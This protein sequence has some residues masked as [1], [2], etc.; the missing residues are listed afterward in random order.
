APRN[1]VPYPASQLFFSYQPGPLNAIYQRTFTQSCGGGRGNACA[2]DA[3]A[4]TWTEVKDVQ[5]LSYCQN[6]NSHPG[7]RGSC[8]APAAFISISGDA[9]A[10]ECK[11]AYA[12]NLDLS[13][14]SLCTPLSVPFETMLGL[15]PDAFCN[16]NPRCAAFDYKIVTDYQTGAI[17]YEITPGSVTFA[18]PYVGRCKNLKCNPIDGSCTKADDDVECTPCI[19][20]QSAVSYSATTSGTN[21]IWFS[22]PGCLSA[23][24][25]SPE[26]TCSGTLTT[27]DVDIN[28]FLCHNPLASNNPL[29]IQPHLN[30]VSAFYNPG[31]LFSLPT[32]SSAWIPSAERTLF[33]GGYATQLPS[34]LDNNDIEDQVVFMFNTPQAGYQPALSSSSSYQ[35]FDCCGDDDNEHPILL[36]AQG[37]SC[38]QLLLGQSSPN[39]AFCCNNP[40]KK[41]NDF[42][43]LDIPGN[44]PVPYAP[45]MYCVSECWYLASPSSVILQSESTTSNKRLFINFAGQNQ[46]VREG[47]A[48][49]SQ[50]RV[51]FFAGTTCLNLIEYT[52]SIDSTLSRFGSSTQ[53]RLVLNLGNSQPQRNLCRLFVEKLN[54]NNY[55]MVYVLDL[56]SNPIPIT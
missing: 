3:S 47:N 39:F 8:K 12:L 18:Q 27:Y 15:Y 35:V 50:Y 44:V 36:S 17:G 25:Q 30:M 22:A 11:D 34:T 55:E 31:A 41:I 21:R 51:R 5:G 2:G 10:Q 53:N 54:G 37:K 7:E 23:S 13:S 52:A 24:S 26:D 19:A 1:L 33:H 32:T 43:L 4:D 45:G 49:L 42:A 9:L 20:D 6:E 40:N 29:A 14:S 38:R 28:E 16:V 46:L 56:A 48:D